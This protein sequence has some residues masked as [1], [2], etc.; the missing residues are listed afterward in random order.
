M[1]TATVKTESGLEKKIVEIN[2][3]G[4]E[5][6]GV[7]LTQESSASGE[8]GSIDFDFGEESGSDDLIGEDEI[9]F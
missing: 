2:A 1:Q 5:I 9:P 6:I 4:I 8:S 3:H 7:S